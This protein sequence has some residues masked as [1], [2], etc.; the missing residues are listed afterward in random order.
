MRKNNR[1]NLAGIWCGGN[2]LLLVLIIQF[3]IFGSLHQVAESQI[4]RKKPPTITKTPPV[5]PTKKL[6]F[7]GKSVVPAGTENARLTSELSRK[8]LT[9]EEKKEALMNVMTASGIAVSPNN[10]P[11]AK[12]A[13]LN[14]RTP[15]VENKAHFYI[16]GTIGFDPADQYFRVSNGFVNI[17]LK[18]ERINEIYMIDCDVFPY[19]ISGQNPPF[20]ILGPDGGKTEITLSGNSHLQFFL[21][22][23]NTEWQIFYIDRK[24]RFDVG[25]C[26]ITQAGN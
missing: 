18:P 14:A 7:E 2:R 20:L 24:I 25:T 23:K 3:F 15:F 17:W 8:P 5:A 22:A 13:V 26:E 19:Q 12:Y 1:Q 16:Y 10:F 9:L 6:V 11:V 21:L 4:I